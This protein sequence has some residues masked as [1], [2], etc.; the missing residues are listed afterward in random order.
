MLGMGPVLRRLLPTGGGK[1]LLARPEGVSD[2]HC[3]LALPPVVEPFCDP[4]SDC[5]GCGDVAGSLQDHHLED[6]EPIW[7]PPPVPHPL[8]LH[9]QRPDEPSAD[10]PTRR[11]I[12]P[13]WHDR[14]VTPTRL[15]RQVVFDAA[16]EVCARVPMNP[17]P[18]DLP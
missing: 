13:Q 16:V 15:P 10:L 6:D 1:V 14:K 4:T 11:I 7:V 3:M 5:M 18:V 17:V 9:P 8:H 2:K 12:A